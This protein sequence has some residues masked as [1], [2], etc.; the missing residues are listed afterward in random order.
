MSMNDQVIQYFF[1]LTK[2]HLKQ[3]FGSDQREL[4]SESFE[5]RF[6]ELYSQNIDKMLDKKSKFHGINP[7]FIMAFE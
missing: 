2:N 3:K 7:I 1:L 5:Y 4:L 6:N